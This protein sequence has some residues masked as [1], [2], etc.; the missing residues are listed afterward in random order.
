M[1]LVADEQTDV[2]TLLILL[3]KQQ[4][5]KSPLAAHPCNRT[6]PRPGEPRPRNSIDSLPNERGEA[7]Q[8][9][10]G[11]RLWSCCGGSDRSPSYE[12]S[13]YRGRLLPRGAERGSGECCPRLRGEAGRC[14][15][16]YRPRLL[17][18]AERGGGEY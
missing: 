11:R 10:I 5:G 15:E 13:L 18:E 17:G 2:A 3:V 9:V 12:S 6:H 7:S 1:C 4:R 14:G 8:G 16:V